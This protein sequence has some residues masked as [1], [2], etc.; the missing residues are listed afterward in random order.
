MWK[1]NEFMVFSKS[2]LVNFKQKGEI[3]EIE[4]LGGSV[5]FRQLPSGERLEFGEICKDSEDAMSLEKAVTYALADESGNR[6]FQVDD[7]A[8]L[9]EMPTPALQEIL[10]KFIQKNSFSQKDLE[11]LK[12]NSEP[13]QNSDSSSTSQES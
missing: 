8:E 6:L 4:K 9:K 13:V 5:Y 2:D 12:G 11:N 7:F 1:G 3:V 10:V